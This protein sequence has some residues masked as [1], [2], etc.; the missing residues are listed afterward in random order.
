MYTWYSSFPFSALQKKTKAQYVTALTNYTIKKMDARSTCK[1]VFW[2]HK[3]EQ[4]NRSSHAR[5]TLNPY[6]MADIHTPLFISLLYHGIIMISMQSIALPPKSTQNISI[7][8]QP[9]KIGIAIRTYYSC[10]FMRRIAIS[11]VRFVFVATVMTS[12]NFDLS[13]II[14]Q[15]R[16]YQKAG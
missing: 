15:W 7:R 14:E 2:Q 11:L 3:Q 4:N 8:I 9:C 12:E 16:H 13:I 1:A 6:R 5:L 10:S